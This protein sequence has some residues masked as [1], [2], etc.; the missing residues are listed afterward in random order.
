MKK[1]LVVTLVFLASCLSKSRKEAK[2]VYDETSLKAF[3]LGTHSISEKDAAM[4]LDS[5]LIAASKD[6]AIFRKTISF[7]EFPF[8]NPNSDYRNQSLYAKLLHIQ[9]NSNWYRA[10]EKEIAVGKL[11]LLQQN[12]VGSPAIDFNYLTPAGYKK[13]MYEIK[14]AYTLLYFYSPECNTCKQM[15]AA[16]ESLSVINDKILKKQL[17]VL[18]IY[19]DKDEKTW[20]DHLSEMPSTWTQ[21]R[22]QGEYLY[23]NRIYDL[24]AIPTLYLLDQ[25]K[26][27]LLKD[28]LLISLI[29]EKLN[30]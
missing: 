23:K 20:L 2:H 11:K 5:I 13:Q 6:S 19:V 27:V 30:L 29:E 18:A 1:V 4:Q 9:I 12:N 7:L 25:D 28:C 17:T 10:F 8:S 24:R 16:L 26:K 3:V 14:T 22:D 15:K 21:G